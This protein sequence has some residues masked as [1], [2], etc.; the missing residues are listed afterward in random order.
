MHN[1][2]RVV[3]SAGQV[4]GAAVI[5]ALRDH[6]VHGSVGNCE[7]VGLQEGV[8]SKMRYIQFRDNSAHAAAGVQPSEGGGLRLHLPQQPKLLHRTRQAADLLPL[9]RVLLH[10]PHQGTLQAVAV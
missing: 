6:G 9:R 7:F 2:F 5:Q 3:A 4:S 8:R 10:L 1:R